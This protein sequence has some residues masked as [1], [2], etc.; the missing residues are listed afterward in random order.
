M[1]QQ[2][3]NP[4]DSTLEELEV[5]VGEP[6]LAVTSTSQ[7]NPETKEMLHFI[8]EDTNLLQQDF[9]E[10]SGKSPP[11]LVCKTEL[12]RPILASGVTWTPIPR[13]KKKI[14]TSIVLISWEPSSVE[15]SSI[16]VPSKGARTLPSSPVPTF[17]TTFLHDLFKEFRQL[18]TKLKLSKHFYESFS[19]QEQCRVFQEIWQLTEIGIDIYYG[20][21]DARYIGQVYS[22]QVIAYKVL[23]IATLVALVTVKDVVQTGNFDSADRLSSHPRRCFVAPTSCINV[24]PYIARFFIDGFANWSNISDTL[25]ST[26]GLRLV[27]VTGRDTRLVCHI[28]RYKSMVVAAA[29]KLGHYYDITLSSSSSLFKIVMHKFTQ[30]SVWHACQ[31]ELNH[32]FIIG[33]LIGIKLLDENWQEKYEATLGNTTVTV[34]ACLRKV[35][36]IATWIWT[37][38]VFVWRTVSKGSFVV[39]DF[40]Q[41]HGTWRVTPD[42]MSMICSII[43]CICQ[44]SELSRKRDYSDVHFLEWIHLGDKDAVNF[45]YILVVP[46]T[47]P[48]DLFENYCK[49]N[50][51][52]LMWHT[53]VLI[54]TFSDNNGQ[55]YHSNLLKETKAISQALI[56]GITASLTISL[57]GLMVGSYRHI[58]DLQYLIGCITLLKT[59]WQRQSLNSKLI[60]HTSEIPMAKFLGRVDSMAL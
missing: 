48:H 2:A 50:Q 19:F 33:A 39:V 17:T 16:V 43:V 51:P 31:H 11:H 15:T 40:V 60:P 55:R 53:I 1:Y 22:A 32:G 24:A 42:N 46:S 8:D 30:D 23:V 47:V 20:L 59:W 58:V 45:K 9:G 38:L 41:N 52:N 6:V 3:K 29:K 4:Q 14:K 44:S 37:L 21:Y 10:G 57:Y 12:P 27:L 7:F 25:W 26:I 18:K 13:P 36:L 28:S 35:L 5:K 54:S 34:S 49:T 56:H